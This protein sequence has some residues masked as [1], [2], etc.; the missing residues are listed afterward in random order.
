M[1]GKLPSK[2]QLDSARM[3]LGSQQI[4]GYANLI[5]NEIKKLTPVAKFPHVGK[6]GRTT[7]PGRLRD[8][9]N[10]HASSG[11]NGHH[12][13]VVTVGEKY[14]MYLNRGFKGFVMSALIGRNVPIRLPN[15]AVIFRH[16]S[17]T[18]VGQR[19]ITARD[20]KSGRIMAGNRPLRW[21]HPGVQPMRF[22]ERGI[23]NAMPQITSF[24]AKMM[25][26]Q[27]FEEFA[28]LTQSDPTMSAR[29][30]RR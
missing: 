20:P 24:Y 6:G 8:S 4:D 3:G 13:F 19:R 1:S 27:L 2:M 22:V 5:Q 25:L 11:A 28:R 16:A 29:T 15:G 9:I 18:A 26:W 10:V 12:Q 17:A 14:G 21:Y 7:A 30:R 23:Q